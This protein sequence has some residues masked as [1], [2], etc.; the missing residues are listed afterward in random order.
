M[1]PEQVTEEEYKIFKILVLESLAEEGLGTYVGSKAKEFKDQTIGLVTSNAT[2]S[3]RRKAGEQAAKIM[4]DKKSMK[5]ISFMVDAMKTP[6]DGSPALAEEGLG[7]WL[8]TNFV[9]VLIDGTVGEVL[10]GIDRNITAK[11]S[12]AAG[13]IMGSSGIVIAQFIEDELSTNEK[14]MI[15]SKVMKNNLSKILDKADKKESKALVGL[16]SKSAG[17][18]NYQIATAFL[19]AFFSDAVISEQK[20]AKAAKSKMDKI[21]IKNVG[22]LVADLDKAPYGGLG[23]NSNIVYQIAKKLKGIPANIGLG[24]LRDSIKKEITK[25]LPAEMKDSLKETKRTKADIKAN[26]KE[27]KAKAKELNMKYKEYLETMQEPN[28]QA[29]A[30]T[31][32]IMLMIAYSFIVTLYD[33]KVLSQPILT[34]ETKKELRKKK[35]KMLSSDDAKEDISAGDESSSENDSDSEDV[36]V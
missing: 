8:K 12:N 19:S 32:Q 30:I 2:K 1:K 4:S 35:G 36:A 21:K 22:K 11:V 17:G 18:T 9:D 29:D 23:L 24:K 14:G 5:A 28:E 27:D 13:K 3:L 31:M 16:A 15:G 34:I 26:K 7:S 6:K 25:S 20:W 33:D 10:R